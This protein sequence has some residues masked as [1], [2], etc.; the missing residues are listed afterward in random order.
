MVRMSD[1]SDIRIFKFTFIIRRAGSRFDLSN[2]NPAQA[3]EW[4]SDPH[5][6]KYFA[7]KDLSTTQSGCNPAQPNVGISDPL[8]LLNSF[9]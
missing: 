8:F 6:Y 7:V 9:N 3:N 4:I 2:R 1:L 5:E